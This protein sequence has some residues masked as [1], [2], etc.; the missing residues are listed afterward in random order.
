MFPIKKIFTYSWERINRETDYHDSLYAIGGWITF[1]QHPL[2]Y[3]IWNFLL[4]QPYESETFRIVLTLIA[5]PMILAE[6]WPARFTKYKHTYW[7]MFVILELPF[8]FF[9]MSLQNDFNIVWG[10]AG[11]VGLFVMVFILEWFT[12]II[13]SIIGISIA[14]V[15]YMLTATPPYITTDGWIYIAIYFFAL[16]TGTG[17]NYKK[18]LIEKEK[19]DGMADT[20]GIIAHELRTPLL[21]IKAAI[22]GLEKHLPTLIQS[23]ELVKDNMPVIK[24][25]RAS[26]LK[27][28]E[29]TLKRMDHEVVYS[30]TIIDMLLTSARSRYLTPGVGDKESIVKCTNNALRRYTFVREEDKA[31]VHWQP[32][33]A[34]DFLFRGSETLFNHIIFNLLKNAIY[35]VRKA[36]KGE[37]Y[38]T[39]DSRKNYNKLIFK[40][41]GTGVA[42]KMLPNIFKRF[43]TSTDVGMGLGLYFCK[44]AMES[45]GG[46]ITCRSEFG[47]FTEFTLTFPKVRESAN[48]ST[49]ELKQTMQTD[50]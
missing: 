46:D 3:I 29:P 15:L 14:V 39:L 40:D 35:F 27:G 33:E 30:N 34:Q 20:I 31:L 50:D 19:L 42:P 21:S 5:I 6:Y 13:C 43:Q 16:V 11:L 26:Q 8:Q 17:L 7:L 1:I 37:I 12:L 25:I 22:A 45:F 32:D 38:I 10:P 28:L 48:S 4:I 18:G 36:G 24:K 41:T 47:E 44:L 9:F 49:H 23:Y 2:Y